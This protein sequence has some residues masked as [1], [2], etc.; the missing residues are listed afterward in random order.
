MS[1]CQKQ[2]RIIEALRTLLCSPPFVDT[3]EKLRKVTISFVI[4]V[5]L[6]VRMK[7]LFSHWTN[8]HGHLYLSI[9]ENLPGKIQVS[10]KSNNNIYLT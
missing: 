10:R 8:F 3:L 7:Q 5:F 9:I 2:T 6:S 1:C 4:P